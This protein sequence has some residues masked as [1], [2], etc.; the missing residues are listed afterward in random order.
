[1]S[2]TEISNLI[3]L[4]VIFSLLLFTII[5]YLVLNI[6]YYLDRKK[7]KKYEEESNYEIIK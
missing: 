5:L 6:Q 4:E 3:L 7:R 2:I 1:M